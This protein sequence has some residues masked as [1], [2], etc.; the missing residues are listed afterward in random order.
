M[1]NLL[2]LKRV[3]VVFLSLTLCF[4]LISCKKKEEKKIYGIN[5]ND[6]A[7]QETVE[8]TSKE[9]PVEDEVTEDIEAEDDGTYYEETTADFNVSY[10]RRL[11]KTERYE[12]VISVLENKDTPLSKYYRGIAYFNM[13]KGHHNYSTD[14]RH[15]YQ[16]NAKDLLREVVNTT[17]NDEVR[18]RSLLWLGI[19]VHL[20]DVTYS[21]KQEA[22]RYLTRIERELS[23]TTSYGDSLIAQASVY[24][25]LGEIQKAASIY[26]K[27]ANI[28]D[29]YVYDYESGNYFSPRRASTH[30]LKKIWWIP[31][32]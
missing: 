1:T 5:Y 26:Y 18:A 2:T 14:Q 32:Y 13:T 24:R 27:V 17:D 25:Y 19:L 30:F 6:N 3:F 10:V 29:R 23:H 28:D 20:S 8:E 16:D 31:Q 21:S 11:L 9:K 22:L 4:S 7:T 15:D 12:K